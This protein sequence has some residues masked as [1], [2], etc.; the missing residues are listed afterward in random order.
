LYILNELY[1]CTH[2][3][4]T[5]RR[6]IEEHDVI[7]QG[8]IA[9]INPVEEVEERPRARRKVT[10][11]STPTTR[12]RDNNT[13]APNVL[14]G[15]GTDRHQAIVFR[16]L[17]HSEDR[18]VEMERIIQEYRL[19]R[20]AGQ[21]TN[22]NMLHPRE[23]EIGDQQFREWFMGARQ[24][25][26]GVRSAVA[27]GVNHYA[28]LDEE[29]QREYRRARGL[30]EFGPEE[31][32]LWRNAPSVT[33]TFDDLANS[34]N[35]TEGPF[36]YRLQCQLCRSI[37]LGYNNTLHRCTNDPDATFVPRAEMNLVRILYRHDLF[38]LNL[39]VL[40][41]DFTSNDIEGFVREKQAAAHW[42]LQVAAF[43]QTYLLIKVDCGWFTTI[44]KKCR[45]KVIRKGIMFYY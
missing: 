29:S 11:I 13:L 12:Q 36:H 28:N 5:R 30:G 7:F 9:A 35:F 4:I 32:V 38:Y 20:E 27:T 3:R 23:S 2:H 10:R 1:Y 45:I 22:A 17:E 33:N 26:D 14:Q 24:N 37:S 21:L 16:T 42:L 31:R 39:T 25:I 6:R 15:P 19:S 40:N 34:E 44:V 41:D 8:P 18:R 43:L